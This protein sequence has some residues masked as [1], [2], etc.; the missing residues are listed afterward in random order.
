VTSIG[1]TSGPTKILE[2]DSDVHSAFICERR[3]FVIM[4]EFS[5]A[6]LQKKKPRTTDVFLDRTEVFAVTAKEVLTYRTTDNDK[7]EGCQSPSPTKDPASAESARRLRIAALQESAC[8]RAFSCRM[9]FAGAFFLRGRPRN[10][11][12][13][14]GL[15][16][17]A[18]NIA[19]IA[20]LDPGAESA[21]VSRILSSL[22][23]ILMEPVIAASFSSVV[24]LGVF[25][26]VRGEFIVGEVSLAIFPLLPST[27]IHGRITG[28]HC[29]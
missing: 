12:A 7:F 25:I 23:R 18:I 29:A 1:N 15:K 4:H 21:R 2:L 3:L 24:V 5:G 11:A 27:Y 19:A 9:L 16:I 20:S 8:R 6:D 10:C 22:A 14:A 26:A 28:E 17:L 13:R